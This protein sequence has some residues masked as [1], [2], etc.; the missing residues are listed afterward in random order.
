MHIIKNPE[1]GNL[2]TEDMMLGQLSL[3][4]E[5]LKQLGI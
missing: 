5:S 1:F 2:H 3:V 4:V